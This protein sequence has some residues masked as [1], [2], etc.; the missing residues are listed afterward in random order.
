LDTR[1]RSATANR[2]GKDIFLASYS[3]SSFPFYAREL[4]SAIRRIEKTADIKLDISRI[5]FHADEAPIFSGFGVI[6]RSGSG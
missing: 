2:V 3:I 4:D 5:F 6:P 1:G